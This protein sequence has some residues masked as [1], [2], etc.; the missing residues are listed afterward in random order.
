MLLIIL[1]LVKNILKFLENSFHFFLF[2]L[3]DC[4]MKNK[5][6]SETFTKNG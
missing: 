2:N 6:E 1:Q 3:D 5:K 4:V